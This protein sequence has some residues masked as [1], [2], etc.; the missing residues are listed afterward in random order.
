MASRIECSSAIFAS[1]RATCSS[2][3]CFTCALAVGPQREQPADL[4]DAEAQ[5]AGA[6]NELQAPHVGAA[7]FA[8]AVAGARRGCDQPR[9]FVEA[10]GLGGHPR[11]PGRFADMHCR[12]SPTSRDYRALL[13]SR[14]A[15]VMTETELALMAAL[16][17][18]GDSSTPRTG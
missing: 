5:V 15:F 1:I 11:A 7:E 8:I 9:L 13:R 10:D 3:S 14:S 12:S 6:V 16:A 18:I 4:A 17:S 2:A